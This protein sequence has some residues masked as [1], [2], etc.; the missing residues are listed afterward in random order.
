MNTDSFVKVSGRDFYAIA[1]FTWATLGVRN[2]RNMAAFEELLEARLAEAKKVRA[3]KYAETLR[4]Y[5]SGEYLKDLTQ[6][7]D[8]YK[9]LSV[10]R[11][12]F[13]WWKPIYEESID[14]IKF[15][16]NIDQ[17]YTDLSNCNRQFWANVIGGYHQ[18]PRRTTEILR[19]IYQGGNLDDLFP[20]VQPEPAGINFYHYHGVEFPHGLSSRAREIMCSGYNF[21]ILHDDF[22]EYTKIDFLEKYMNLQDNDC[23]V[24]ISEYNRVMELKVEA[25]EYDNQIHQH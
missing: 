19:E 2:D 22:P 21:E 8:Q 11:V 7:V 17:I 18:T 6:I 5:K 20:D 10:I 14:W 9:T 25:D 15:R 1:M 4:Y 16:S 24:P 23:F 13:L 12:G 3:E